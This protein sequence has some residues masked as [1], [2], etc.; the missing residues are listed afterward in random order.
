MGT[1]TNA[2]NETP[3]A[4]QVSTAS[5][6]GTKAKS[7]EAL[8]LSLFSSCTYP[9]K[10]GSNP[11]IIAGF[12]FDKGLFVNYPK[13]F[14]ISVNGSVDIPIIKTIEN[15][16]NG[17]ISDVLS[18]MSM[19]AK[20]S[21]DYSDPK[22]NKFGLTTDISYDTNGESATIPWGFSATVSNKENSVSA[23]TSFRETDLWKKDGNKFIPMDSFLSFG[24]KIKY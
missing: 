19:Q 5:Y 11:E 15:V 12:D 10:N 8:N 14:K 23:W 22:G 2:V 6:G 20:S 4:A 24:L 13:N 7:Q 18:D 21:I 3:T 1:N 9:L 17:K 16:I